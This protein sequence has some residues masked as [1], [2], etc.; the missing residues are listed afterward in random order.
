[1]TDPKRGYI[2]DRR[3]GR[4]HEVRDVGTQELTTFCGRVYGAASIDGRTSWPPHGVAKSCAPCK[5][6]ALARR[7]A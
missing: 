4:W 6:K 3:S 1:M 2:R 7:R 5:R